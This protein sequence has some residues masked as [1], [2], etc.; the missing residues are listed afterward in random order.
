MEA[1]ETATMP[2]HRLSKRRMREIPTVDSLSV[3]KV[4][5]LY[6]DFDLWKRGENRAMEQFVAHGG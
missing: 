4:K 2:R 6:Q 3:G 1:N 5:P